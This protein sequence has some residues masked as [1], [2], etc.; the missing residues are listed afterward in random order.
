MDSIEK[1]IEEI[2]RGSLEEY[3]HIVQKFQKSIFTYCY[4]MLGA[5]EEAE[6]AVQEVFIKA[7]R[8]LDFYKAGTSFSSWLYKIA[9]NHCV[10]YLRKRKYFC[11]VPLCDSI[12]ADCDTTAYSVEK[13]ELSL[14]LQK[15][16]TM[17]S[18]EDRSV[19]MLRVLEEK[20]YEEIASILGKPLST[21]RKKY[22]RARKRVKLNI[23][24]MKGVII[25]GKFAVN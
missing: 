2:K 1:A 17:L 19:L 18:P 23:D 6:D 8:K 7:Y 25:N 9:Y 11:F 24:K 10:D 12:I 16:I 22:E 14:S 20:S 4:H 5:V 3:K 13:D 15:A 21:V